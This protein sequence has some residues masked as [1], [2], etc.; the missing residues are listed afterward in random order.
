MILEQV[1]E[2]NSPIKNKRGTRILFSHH[3]LHLRLQAIK[4]L[5]SLTYPLK[6]I[7]GQSTL[8]PNMSHHLLLVNIRHCVGLSGCYGHYGCGW[9]LKLLL[10]S[11]DHHCPVLDLEVLL[12][13]LVLEVY[14]RVRVLVLHLTSDV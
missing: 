13:N 9:H 11:G 10:E 8:H 3:E 7:K 1:A 2:M 6:I 5:A 4:L 12:L 14:D